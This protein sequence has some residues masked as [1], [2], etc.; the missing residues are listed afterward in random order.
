MKDYYFVF[1]HQSES[2]NARLI[3]NWEKEGWRVM[4]QNDDRI[5]FE[6]DVEAVGTSA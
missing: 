6:R 4:S 5:Y 2:K 1:K 3:A